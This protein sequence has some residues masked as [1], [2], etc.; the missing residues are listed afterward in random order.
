VDAGE[1]RDFGALRSLPRCD[2]REAFG[3]VTSRRWLP[4]LLWA[5]RMGVIA[6]VATDLGRVDA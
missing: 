2:A 5:A 4:P 1:R 6:A 3:E